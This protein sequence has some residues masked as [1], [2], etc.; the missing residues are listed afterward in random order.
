MSV[1]LEVRN[2][3]KSFGGLMA[4]SDVSFT[5]RE[6]EIVGLIGPNGAGK[7]TTFNLLV[8]LHKCDRGEILLRG[9]PIHNLPP[10]EV[11]RR[12]ITKTFQISTLFDDMSVLDNAVVGALL[13][14]R[15][16]A[17]AV[18]EA[19]RALEVVGLD[20][21]PTLTPSDLNVVD[22]ARL[23]IARALAT[24][25]VVLL[26][27]EVMAGQT[28]AETEETIAMIRCLRDSGITLIVVEHNMR[29]IMRLSDRIIA[30][31]YG[32]KIADGPPR[33]V[34]AHPEVIESYLGRGYAVAAG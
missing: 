19:R 10:H 31:H 22:R 2:L 14:H 5:V 17:E 15:S 25:P 11:A 16:V 34:S 4:V 6:G 21:D 29:A 12:G 9:E 33:E 26:L 8:G 23:E 28:P 7:T 27:D 32:R 13:R 30:F 24:R 3:T 1:I 20:P 18:A